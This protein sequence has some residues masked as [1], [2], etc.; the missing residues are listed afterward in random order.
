MAGQR[1]SGR[2]I[3]SALVTTDLVGVAR[4]H[5]QT[6]QP[7]A[8]QPIAPQPIAPQ[9]I[10]QQPITQQAITQ[11]PARLETPSGLLTLYQPQP[12]KFDGN[13]LTARAAVSLTPTGQTEPQFGAIW[14][15]ARVSADR[16]TH[17]VTIQDIEVKQVKLPN[18][19]PEQDKQFGWISWKQR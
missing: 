13:L 1:T 7:I 8:P 10:A 15:H 12:D 9:P 4:S 11:W 2:G 16:D 6:A 19:T 17:Q 14:F 18:A 5:A 3:F